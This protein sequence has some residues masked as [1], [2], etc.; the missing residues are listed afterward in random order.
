MAANQTIAFPG[1][2]A[3]V[4]SRADLASCDAWPHAF[5][6]KTK[7]HRFYEIVA[8]TLGEK[9]KHHY[10]LLE[11][12]AGIVRAVQP[13]FFVQQN[14]IEG[15][16]ALRAAVEIVR[17]QFPRFLTMRVLMVGNAAG[18]GHLSACDPKD[19]AWVANALAEIL[20][21]YARQARASLVV[22]KDFP[23]RYRASLRALESSGY[24]RVPSM[25]MTEL[26]LDY[27]DF[28]HYVTTLGASTRK[29]LRRKFRRIAGAKPITVEVVTDLTPHVEEL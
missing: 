6:G 8:D 26:T 7:D 19:E 4:L 29:D 10:L 21:S 28:D 13:V 12:H 27:R 23:A 18:E 20:Q 16:P 2:I 24:T 1:G 9:F 14:L 17:R 3:R 11:D 5:A 25:P 22:F 15:I